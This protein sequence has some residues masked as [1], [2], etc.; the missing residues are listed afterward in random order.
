MNRPVEIS[1]YPTE[2]LLDHENV[3]ETEDQIALK[4]SSIEE[5]AIPSFEVS[6]EAETMMAQ[7]E[8]LT[9]RDRY[10]LTTLDL[11]RQKMDWMIPRLKNISRE[12]KK[13]NGTCIQLKTWKHKV[14]NDVDSAIEFTKKHKAELAKENTIKSFFKNTV[15]F[16]VG[17]LGGIGGTITIASEFFSL[18]KN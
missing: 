18:I 15:I 12:V 16:L 13:T 3:F 17:I 4:L 8:N 7:M 14:E 10:I 5:L 9:P 1:T 11:I 2:S 6:S